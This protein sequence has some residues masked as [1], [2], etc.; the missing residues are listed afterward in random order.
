MDIQELIN[1]QMNHFVK[2]LS[3]K[4]E[5]NTENVL[6][7]SA[8]TASYLIRTRH[9]NNNGITNEEIEGVLYNISVFLSEGFKDQIFIEDLTAMKNKTLELLKNPSFD[10]YIG[11]YFKK[12]Y[13]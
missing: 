1:N 4:N 5:L 12:F 7:V 13:Q 10:H 2:K 9:I 3:D 8:H 6:D 11:D